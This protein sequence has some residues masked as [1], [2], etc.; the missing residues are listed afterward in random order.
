MYLL[1]RR[2]ICIAKSWPF[3]YCCIHSHNF[4]FFFGWGTLFQKNCEEQPSVIFSHSLPPTPP[5]APVD[6]K[7]C[8][9]TYTWD[10]R[11]VSLSGG[12]IIRGDVLCC[13]GTGE[14]SINCT[15]K[16]ANR[17]FLCLGR[18]CSKRCVA[19][20]QCVPLCVHLCVCVCARVKCCTSRDIGG[21]LTWLL[22]TQHASQE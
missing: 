14:A 22:P 20:M 2:H 21:V 1:S 4:C 9:A 11:V 16:H 7:H 19:L 15:V 6:F 10:T 13:F 12:W 3:P 17:S 8:S 5:F 18:I